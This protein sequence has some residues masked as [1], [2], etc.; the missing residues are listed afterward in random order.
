[1]TPDRSTAN[2]R[3]VRPIPVCTSSAM[4]RIPWRRQISATSGMNAAGGTT[5]PPSPCT[6]SISTAAT[7]SGAR[8]VSRI[9]SRRRACSAAS[10]SGEPA[11]SGRYGYGYGACT[12]FVLIDRRNGRREFFVFPVAV[13][14]A[15]VR[16]WNAFWNAITNSRLVAAR[17]IFI[18]FSTA[19]APLFM[20]TDLVASSVLPRG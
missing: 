5:N 3:P 1:M 7:C 16:P 10:S 19:S 9:C 14:A 11:V 6:G 18:A 12:T 17:A 2:I 8:F 4:S 15:Y 20:K 13:I